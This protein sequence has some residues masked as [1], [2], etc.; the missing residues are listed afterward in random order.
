[1]S[2]PVTMFYCSKCDFQQGDVGTWGLR[3]YVL[4]SGVRIPVNWR[5]GW[6][7]TCEGIAAIEDLSISRRIKDYRKAELQL[8][9]KS[10]L[11]GHS[12][13]ESN[14]LDRTT[15]RHF[16]D[17]MQDAIDALE[18]LSTRNSPPHCLNCASTQVQVRDHENANNAGDQKA[19][20]L[21][22]NCGGEINTKADD[23]GLRI[24]L[25]PSVT[26]FTP[27][28]MIIKKEYVG[29]YSAPDDEY[30]DALS[31]SN[32]QCRELNLSVKSDE[33][34]MSIPKFLLKHTD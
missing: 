9:Q 21:H 2:W 23:G 7:E 29:G 1:M 33:G 13:L 5:I 30:W 16:E 28:G 14:N 18:M 6:C 12:L 34:L 25:R 15:L 24:A 8:S 22:P 19:I 26:S 11:L 4:E 32:R 17:N 3:E 31:A 10:R 20:W 27:E